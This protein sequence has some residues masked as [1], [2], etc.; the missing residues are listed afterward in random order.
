MLGKNPET[1]RCSNQAAGSSSDASGYLRNDAGSKQF[2]AGNA[3]EDEEDDGSELTNTIKYQSMEDILEYYYEPEKLAEFD[4]V[5]YLASP[6]ENMLLKKEDVEYL[7]HEIMNDETAPQEVAELSEKSTAILESFKKCEEFVSGHQ[8]A[9]AGDAIE[10][11]A[12]D[13]SERINDEL[14]EMGPN[15][16]RWFTEDLYYKMIILDR[17]YGCDTHKMAIE[18][19][20]MSEPY[21]AQKAEALRSAQ[22][23][24]LYDNDNFNSSGSQFSF[25][26]TPPA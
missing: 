23:A 2:K 24:A 8:D 26:K 6:L 10:K 22:K 13:I 11:A 21:I 25:Y 1:K 4:G 19:N 3:V 20:T 9:D 15:T 12:R 17:A 5:S 7:L 14:G 16:A 18:L